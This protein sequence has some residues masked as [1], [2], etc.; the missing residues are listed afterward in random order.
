M[1]NPM[2]ILQDVSFAYGKDDILAD[3]NL[4]VEQQEY[5]GIIGGNGAKHT[6]AFDSW[7]VISK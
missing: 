7:T 2:I 1:G 5:V 3:V 4:I 6:D